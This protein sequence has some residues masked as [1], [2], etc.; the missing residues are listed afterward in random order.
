[1]NKIKNKEFLF[2]NY[3]KIFKIIIIF[4]F[5]EKKKN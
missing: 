2:K 5:L 3:L 4:L 1:M